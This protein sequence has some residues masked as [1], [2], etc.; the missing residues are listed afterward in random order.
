MHP[1]LTAFP[2]IKKS[3]DYKAKHIS[4]RVRTCLKIAHKRGLK[5][6]GKN[7]AYKSVSHMQK[8]KQYAFKGAKL[9][10]L[11]GTSSGKLHDLHSQ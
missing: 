3:T 6:G 4:S 9:F 11:A 1:L 10:G 2:T 7:V 8:P 5:K